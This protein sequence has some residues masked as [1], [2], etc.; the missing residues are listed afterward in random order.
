MEP[1]RVHNLLDGEAAQRRVAW[2]LERVGLKP[3]HA[4]AIRTNFLA[5]S[6]SV[7]ALPGHWPSI[8]KW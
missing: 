2:L 6:D 5:V 4:R 8:R 1:L 7:S 3:E